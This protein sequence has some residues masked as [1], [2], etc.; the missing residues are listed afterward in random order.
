MVL[1]LSNLSWA[2]DN[3]IYVDQSGNDSTIDMLQTGAGNVIRGIQGA[4]TGN[5]T[6][7]KMYGNNSVVDIKQVGSDNTANIGYTVTTAAGYAYGIDLT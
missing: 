4:G 2:A 7:A 3:S 5:T 6:P 1:L